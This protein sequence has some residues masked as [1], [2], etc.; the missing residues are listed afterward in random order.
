MSRLLSTLRLMTLLFYALCRFEFV[1]FFGVHMVWETVNFEVDVVFS[2]CR[3]KELN[4]FLLLCFS[5]F[6]TFFSFHF[7]FWLCSL[8]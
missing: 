1:L 8:V 7:I 2:S 4:L 6:L 3:F 5:Q